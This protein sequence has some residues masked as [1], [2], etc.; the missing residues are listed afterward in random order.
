MSEK[1]TK[2]TILFRIVIILIAL[3]IGVAI[4]AN[5]VTKKQPP[6]RVQ[7]IESQLPVQVIE[8][9]KLPFY[10]KASG[11]GSA[12]PAKTYSAI[13][14]V[15][16]RVV[17]RHKDLES[18]A[19]L[20]KDSLLMEI[21]D[22]LYQLALT[23]ANAEIASLDAEVAQLKQEAINI[24]ALLTLESQRLELAETDLE[25]TSKLVNSGSISRATLDAQMRATL[26]QRQAVQSLVN[27]QNILP[28]KLNQLKAQKER[29]LTKKEQVKR[30]IKDTKF[31]APF[32]MR[33]S[34]VKAEMHQYIN[35]GQSLFSGDGIDVSEVVLQMPMQSLRRVLTELPDD[36]QNLNLSSLSSFVSLVDK[37]QKWDA[38]VMR[39]ANGID[40]AT[41]T[42]RVVLNVEQPTGMTSQIHNP[43][44]V[45]GMYVE[46]V[47]RVK[48]GEPKIII[49]QYALHENWVYL[50]DKDARL[51]RV[52]IEVDFIQDGMVVVKSGLKVGQTIIID[53]IIPAISGSL[54]K[55]NRN[56]EVEENLKNNALGNEVVGEAQ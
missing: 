16:G 33:I 42:I 1:T 35:P 19:L 7:N 54:L 20:L 6:K 40:P 18:G 21:D 28:I 44:L 36:T 13:S 45:K 32:D 41:R 47:L 31:F 9:A 2:K 46:G 50:V 14:N 22:G 26:Q 27:Q 39:I 12:T 4:I 37:S 25:R 49:P 23:E 15:K 30:D 11:F 3:V 10:I 53:D 29:A 8:V 51:E 56:L 17:F 34:E 5:F 48:A 43:P 55:A 24:E 38:K 52:K